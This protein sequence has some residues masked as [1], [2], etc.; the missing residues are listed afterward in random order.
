MTEAHGT[1]SV[2]PHASDAP[3]SGETLLEFPS[4]FPI[5]A[6]GLAEQDIATLVLEILA[7][8]TDGVAPEQVRHR[9]ST[10]GKWLSVTVV[11]EAQSKAQLDA[12]YRELTA[13]EAIVYAL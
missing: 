7:R 5:K 3:E 10:N 11:F 13:H 1:V 9:P 4:Q 6:M 8:H 12:I 2:D